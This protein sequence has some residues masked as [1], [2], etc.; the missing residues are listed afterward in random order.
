MYNDTIAVSLSEGHTYTVGFFFFSNF[1]YRF[2]QNDIQ[3]A[4]TCTNHF[5]KV[6]YFFYCY[7]KM[8]S[9]G[10]NISVDDRRL[11]KQNTILGQ[12]KKNL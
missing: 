1:I 6:Q 5:T 10:I 4:H 3:K 9:V 11:N 2:D 7:G 8:T 12:A